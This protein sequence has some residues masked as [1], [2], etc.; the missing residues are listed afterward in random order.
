MALPLST[1]VRAVRAP[2][3][4][5]I[6][7]I[8][9]RNEQAIGTLAARQCALADGLASAYVRVDHRPHDPSARAAL[10]TVAARLSDVADVYELLDDVIAALWLTREEP[11]MRSSLVMYLEGVQRWA[12]ALV[13]E[14]CA[15][16][17][18]L[19]AMHTD[20]AR[21]RFR[22]ALAKAEL[23]TELV[24]SVGGELASM[25]DADV[26]SALADLSFSLHVLDGNLAQRFG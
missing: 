20:W 11:R 16:A 14:L 1:H 2:A 25:D 15:L 5:G 13:V 3:D 19:A 18:E 17:T 23:P 8:A 10:K 7:L 22:L 21:F 12:L 26:T 4:S 6:R 24:T 9:V